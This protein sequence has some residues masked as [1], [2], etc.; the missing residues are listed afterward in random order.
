[1]QINHRKLAFALNGPCRVPTILEAFYDA[2]N[3]SASLIL[4]AAIDIM[5]F[6]LSNTAPLFIV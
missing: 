2:T 1:M 3:L 4:F 5:L 6:G